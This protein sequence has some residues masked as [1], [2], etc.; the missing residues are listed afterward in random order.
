MWLLRLQFATK[1][2]F[3]REFTPA[4][5]F[6]FIAPNFWFGPNSVIVYT[7]MVDVLL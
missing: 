4:S 3:H 7:H 6:E 2:I 5:V 1:L